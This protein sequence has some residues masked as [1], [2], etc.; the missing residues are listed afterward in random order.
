MKLSEFKSHL[1][2]CSHLNFMLPEGLLI[3][4]HFHITEAGLST[5]HFIDC[6]GTERLEKKISFQI[7]TSTD[8]DHRLE[9]TKLLSIIHKYEQVIDST[10][11]DIEFEYQHE[12]INKYEL[13]FNNGYF[14]LSN[15]KTACLAEEACGLPS[16]EGT[17]TNAK[18]NKSLTDLTPSANSCCTPNSGC[19][20]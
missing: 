2:N 4:S 16:F 15:T 1:S 18:V 5:K 20:N 9:P 8:T 17:L 11:L 7:W 14:I 19:C 3:P 6:G 13:K 12:T 10:D